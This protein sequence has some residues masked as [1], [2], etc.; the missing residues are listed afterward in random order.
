LNT[1]HSPL[2]QLIAQQMAGS[3]QH[4]LTFAEFMDLALYHPQ[5]GYY[6]TRALRIGTQGDFFTSPHLAPDFGELLG[7]QFVQMWDVMQRPVPFTLV[8]MGA[9]QGL[10]AADILRYLHRHFPEFCEGLQ[11]II[12]ERAVPLIAEQQRQLRSLQELG[13]SIRWQTLDEIPSGS[14]VGC[15][16]SNELVDALPVHQIALEAEQMRE[17]YVTVEGDV[18]DAHGHSVTSSGSGL[19]PVSFREVLGPLSTP[20][21]ADYFGLINIELGSSAYPDGYR[22]E[23]NLA[24][25]DW[26]SRIAD[27]IQH[28]F[29]LTID[30][31][32]TSDRYYSPTRTQGT[33]QCYYHHAHHGDPY[34]HIG[35][36]DI[37]AHVDFTA[38]QRWGDRHQL[39]TVG[40]TQQGLFLLALGLGDRIAALSQTSAPTPQAIHDTL[41]QREALHQLV[42]P[43]GLGNFGVLI[44]SKGLTET[45]PLKGL[46]LPKL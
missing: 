33:L 19:D 3:P 43:L 26:L 7:E 18:S 21:L 46:S 14:V 36:Q 17:I 23:V 12:V 15:C 22:T 29:L 5:S 34:I 20:A 45:A 11:Y 16:F 2:S 9:G 44:Q 4:R 37:T 25:L 24:A 41:R 27:R 8:E 28:G 30:Y 35:D 39:K 10:L 32:Y 6:A 1:A 13:L 42:S 31:G 38:L 40:F